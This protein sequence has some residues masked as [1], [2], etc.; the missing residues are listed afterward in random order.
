MAWW[1]VGPGATACSA[2]IVAKTG[3]SRRTAN[4][5]KGV[6]VLCLR[7]GEL[8]GLLHAAKE[9]LEAVNCRRC[10]SRKAWT[11]DKHTVA[12]SCDSVVRVFMLELSGAYLGTERSLSGAAAAKAR[13]PTTTASQGDATCIQYCQC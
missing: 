13:A 4:C 9:P 12:S 2:V 5:W 1:K 3:C 11:S 6:T 7:V 10:N 8:L